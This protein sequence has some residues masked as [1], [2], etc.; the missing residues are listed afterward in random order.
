MYRKGVRERERETECDSLVTIIKPRG[1]QGHCLEILICTFLL[2]IMIFLQSVNSHGF[3]LLGLHVKKYLCLHTFI[4]Y[5]LFSVIL[6]FAPTYA[7][8]STSS[9]QQYPY[10]KVDFSTTFYL[11]DLSHLHYYINFQF[12]TFEEG[13]FLSQ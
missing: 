2:W 13:I 6:I 8:V 3:S 1:T 4:F 5:F 10:H 9:G 7:H 12:I 11:I